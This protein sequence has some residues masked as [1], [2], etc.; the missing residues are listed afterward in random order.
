VPVIFTTFF[1]SFVDALIVG[2]GKRVLQRDKED[3]VAGEENAVH[4]QAAD[5]SGEL[6]LGWLMLNLTQ[7]G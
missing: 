2:G 7:V 4:R 6:T 3:L 1:Q 5:I